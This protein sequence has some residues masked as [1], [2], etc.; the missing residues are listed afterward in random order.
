MCEVQSPTP[1]MTIRDWFTGNAQVALDHRSTRDK[2]PL[3]KDGLT[4][5]QL[6]GHPA[7]ALADALLADRGVK[8]GAE[9]ASEGQAGAPSVGV[10]R[11][12]NGQ[13]SFAYRN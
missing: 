11:G 12:C 10:P 7:Y 1:D 2:F 9:A 4:Y 13:K 3:L 5:E 6:I 8:A